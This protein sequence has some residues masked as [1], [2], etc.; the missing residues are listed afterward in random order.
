[1]WGGSKHTLLLSCDK[2]YDY[3]FNILIYRC[4]INHIGLTVSDGSVSWAD[5]G[6][7]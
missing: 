6:G 3:T 7:A 1:M 2:L 4:W 5:E